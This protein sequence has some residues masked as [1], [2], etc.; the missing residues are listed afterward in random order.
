VDDV[1]VLIVSLITLGD[2]RTL[3]GGYLYHQRVAALAPAFDARVRFVS[4]PMAPFP[5]P[6][7]P[8]PVALCRAA[9][10]RPDVLLIDSIAAAYVGPWL[11]ALRPRLP[12]AGM[13][14]QPPGG[15]DHGR[16]R[17]RVQA[18]L[19]RLA[20]SRATRLLVASASLADDLVAQGV[21][22][23]KLV[24]VSPGR[25]VASERAEP[26]GD[27]RMGRRAALVSVGNWVARKGLLDLLDAVSR[28][29]DDAATLHL[30]G[31]TDV[32]LGY[33]ARVRAR[34][35]APD[36]AGRVVVHGPLPARRVAALYAAADVFVLASIREPYGTVYGEA[37]A[38]G[39][40]VVGYRAGNLPHLIDDG[41]Q[42][43]IVPPGDV[44]ALAAALGRLV[45]DPQVRARMGEGAARRAA[46]FPTWHDSAARLFAELRAAAASP[47]T[48]RR[49]RM[50]P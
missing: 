31:D 21:P 29:P 4:I 14:H 7:V 44:V 2:P 43:L 1:H 45:G 26:S 18:K 16:L 9:R 33:S 3:T 13:L 22:S 38:A 17:T 11:P 42:G 12:V 46:T 6:A 27:L 39:L 15:I 19:D 34:L 37:M 36:L 40:P 48:T 5:L 24:V 35:R 20:Y 23:D 49:E 41:E 50:Q 10:Q 47:G 32:E 25:D 28:L 8:A 30:V